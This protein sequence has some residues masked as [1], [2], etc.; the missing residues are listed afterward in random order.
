[1]HKKEEHIDW[2]RHDRDFWT[3]IDLDNTLFTDWVVTG[4]FYESVHWVEAFLATK[5][6]H[7][8]KHAERKANIVSH[9]SELRPIWNNFIKLET[10]S[11]NARYECYKHT[12]KEAQQ[13][14]P[15]VD[16]IKGHI[17]QLL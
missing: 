16:N 13:L 4:M 5:S 3:S 15:L 2:A 7:S 6:Q 1:M 17:S 9:K 8:K 12:A 10:D 11:R 14:I